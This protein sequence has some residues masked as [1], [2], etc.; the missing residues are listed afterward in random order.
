M[1]TTA[2]PYSEKGLR[3][4]FHSATIIAPRYKG[5][6]FAE[7]FHAIKR[8][9]PSAQVGTWTNPNLTTPP[10]DD[11]DVTMLLFDDHRLAVFALDAPAPPTF[12]QIGMLPNIFMRDPALVGRGHL[13]HVNVMRTKPPQ[14]P[15]EALALSR[16]VTIVAL[17]AATLVDGLAIK[18]T[19]ADHIVP[20]SLIRDALPKLSPPGGIAPTLWARL[21]VHAG[22]PTPEGAKTLVVG[23]VG[24][25]AFGLRDI[26]CAPSG[27]PVNELLANTAAMSE[28]LL[29]QD[30]ELRDGETIGTPERGGFTIDVKPR[31][32][33]LDTPICLLTPI[34]KTSKLQGEGHGLPA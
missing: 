16:A 12:F 10:A 8:I 32:L 1:T 15:A 7:L 24:L 33:F 28:Y 6:T 17:A 11:P 27:R 22:Q 4:A 29:Q 31:G 34:G 23:T 13:S 9:S 18:W 26:E 20:P 5:V 14:S 2:S 19:D 3:P 30:T 21:L 25:H